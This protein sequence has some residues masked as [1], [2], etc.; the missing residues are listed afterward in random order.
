M[1]IQCHRPTPD[2]P[3][4]GLNDQATQ[5]AVLLVVLDLHPVLITA[6]EL[7]RQ[8][9]RRPH[10]FSERDRIERAVD[11]LAGGGLLHRH[12]YLNRPD[13]LITPTR[14]AFLAQELLSDEEDGN[15]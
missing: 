7:V 1:R 6:S 9:S 11:E 10:E 2:D 5:S 3:T 13:A 15:D 12:D 8:M 4:P 14:A